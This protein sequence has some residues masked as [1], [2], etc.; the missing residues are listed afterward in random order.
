MIQI[1]GIDELDEFI[2]EGS[3]NNK[4]IVLY[5]GAVWCGPCKLL[6]ERLVDSDTYKSMPRL[7]VCYLDVDDTE[8]D[9][10]VEKYKVQ[11]FPTQI[12]IRLNK[13]QVL[14]VSRVEGYDF[15]KLKLEYDRYL[16]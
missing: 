10:L 3:D 15:T 11:A 7:Y 6:K 5:F 14:E 13:N 12:F 2:L 16:L 1:S 9:E 8:N 4:V